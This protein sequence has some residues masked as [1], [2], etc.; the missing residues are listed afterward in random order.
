MKGDCCETASF[1]RSLKTIYKKM[2]NKMKK[3]ILTEKQ[4][5]YCVRNTKLD[6]D[7]NMVDIP[8]AIGKEEANNAPKVANAFAAAKRYGVNLVPTPQ[9]N[10]TNNTQTTPSA[11]EIS[12]I[13][14]LTECYTKKEFKE[15]F[16]A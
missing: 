11:T 10:D 7:N 4:L 6:E 15:K 8:A 9:D 16:G 2:S 3:V 13:G 14:N 1:F 5:K 12:K